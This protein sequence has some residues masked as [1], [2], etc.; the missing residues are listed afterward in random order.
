[1]YNKWNN[2]LFIHLVIRYSL[3]LNGFEFQFLFILLPICLKK[4]SLI[5]FEFQIQ[6]FSSEERKAFSKTILN[7]CQISNVF[8]NVSKSDE[9]IDFVFNRKY[10]YDSVVF[11]S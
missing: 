4:L 11:E 3:T 5:W 10:F 9:N 2:N 7:L 8:S 1:M 6:V